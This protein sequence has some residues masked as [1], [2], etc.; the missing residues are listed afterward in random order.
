MCIT[1]LR[2]SQWM[3]FSAAHMLRFS[4]ETWSSRFRFVDYSCDS[5]A[6][7]FPELF[8][9]ASGSGNS[10]SVNGLLIDSFD[11]IM[12]GQVAVD[13][14]PVNCI[15]WVESQELPMLEFLVR[16]QPKEGHGVF[17]GGWER[18]RNVF[19]AAKNYAKKLEREELEQEQSSRSPNSKMRPS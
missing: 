14:C 16:P 3:T 11:A 4:L 1:Q 9:V 19:A 7:S 15:H 12:E 17:G 13:S 6:K 5:A 2:R 8:G 10:I 18:P